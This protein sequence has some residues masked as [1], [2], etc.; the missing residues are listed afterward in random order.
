MHLKDKKRRKTTKKI[1][2][3]GMSEEKRSLNAML[4]ER[5]TCC[6]VVNALL[7]ILQL[8]WLISML[9]MSQSSGGGGYNFL[10]NPEYRLRITETLYKPKENDLHGRM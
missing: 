10:G 9:K 1:R 6:D 8:M 7:S 4:V 5:K 2:F 3:V